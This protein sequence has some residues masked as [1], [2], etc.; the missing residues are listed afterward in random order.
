MTSNW[1]LCVIVHRVYIWIKLNTTNSNRKTM[2]FTFCSWIFLLKY[3]LKFQRFS[4]SLNMDHLGVWWE[5]SCGLLEKNAINAESMYLSW[6]CALSV[7]QNHTIL[8]FCAMYLS[9]VQVQQNRKNSPGVPKTHV[10]KSKHFRKNILSPLWCHQ[11]NLSE[12]WAEVGSIVQY[13][14]WFFWEIL[15]GIVCYLCQVASPSLRHWVLRWNCKKI[16]R[17]GDFFFSPIPLRELH[18]SLSLVTLFH[19]FC[20]EV[21][22]WSELIRNIMIA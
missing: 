22:M 9:Q 18:S 8:S 15:G 11:V 12:P 2:C 3:M 6:D 5:G 1:T 4:C 14:F 20:V 21:C 19:F 16:R 13:L 17:N 7:S 10:F